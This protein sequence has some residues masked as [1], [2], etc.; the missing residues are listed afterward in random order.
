MSEVKGLEANKGSKTLQRNQKMSMVSKK[1]N[2]D[3]K[4]GIQFLVEN[5]LL[6]HMAKDITHFLY[7][8]EGLNKRGKSSVLGRCVSL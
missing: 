8:G 3:P 4:N 2:T 1:L 7:E 6:Q 5:K